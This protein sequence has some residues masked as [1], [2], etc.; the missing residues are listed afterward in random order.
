[1]L[2]SSIP[3]LVSMFSHQPY[4]IL[5]WIGLGWITMRTFPLR[6]ASTNLLALFLVMTSLSNRGIHVR[7][8]R[9]KSA[10]TKRKYGR[11]LWW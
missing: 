10:C 8:V 2:P 11:S 1:M 9:Y 6:L 5:D 3:K 4:I 7:S